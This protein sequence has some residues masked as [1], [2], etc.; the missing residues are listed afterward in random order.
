MRVLIAGS[1]AREHALA[2]ACSQGHD[3]IEVTCAP[4]NGGTASFAQNVPVAADDPEGIVRTARDLDAQ[5]VVIGPDAALAAGVADA[6]AAAKIAVFGP[7][8]A[9]ARI[10]SS[11]TFAKS[12]MDRAGIPTA[13]WC[14][15]TSATRAALLGFVED[16][17]GQCVVKA[18]G[19]ALGKGV[20]VCGGPDEARAAIAACL[21][22][23]RFGSAGSQ[24][25]V[26]ERLSGPE[27]TVLAL[28]DGSNIRVLPVA[29]DYKR[30]GDSDTGP[31]TGGMGAVTPPR[32][33]ADTQPS[34]APTSLLADIERDVL[35][36][37]V[38]A[39][40]AAGTPFA[41]C[42]YA[43]L[44]LTADGPRV[45]EFNARFGDPEAQVVL[46]VLDAD[47][48]A[49]LLDCAHG[50]LAPGRVYPA[51]QPAAVG[52]VLAAAGYPGPPRRGDAITGLQ[53]LDQ[54]ILA[55]HAG[56][57]RDPD[58]TVRSDGGRVLTLV[59][60]GA[61]REVARDRVYACVPDVH[62]EGMH[63]RTDIGRD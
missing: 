32:G 12:L 15:G 10:E 29:R 17:G 30:I 4:G 28:S 37:C 59:A 44:M 55:F 7:T 2:W 63:Y 58:G 18:D 5:L 57:R 39:L 47:V 24:V 26:E 25:I 46:P 16:L 31:N 6:C 48:L 62:F 1:G 42:L 8:A 53:Q 20:T 35:R 52:V 49:L 11:K 38:D 3:D 40:A 45:V 33:A 60:R 14:S 13:R 51:D 9:A 50:T 23:Q 27:I 43:Q 54:S 21:D 36:P 61:S 34:T 22:E 19:L 56:T 41:G